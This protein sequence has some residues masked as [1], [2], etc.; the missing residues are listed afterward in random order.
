MADEITLPTSVPHDDGGLRTTAAAI[1]ATLSVTDPKSMYFGRPEAAA[2]AEANVK[3]ALLRANVTERPAAT[4][5]QIAA[6][7]HSESF[8]FL[9]MNPNLAALV[10]ERAAAVT[11]VEQAAKVLRTQLGAATYDAMVADARHARSDL[12]GAAGDV[13]AL[14]ILASHGKYLAAHNRTKPGAKP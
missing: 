14:R 6:A 8:R 2:A 9:T 5:E 12:A 1:R 13:H 4:A 11:N 10:D 3:A 7:Q